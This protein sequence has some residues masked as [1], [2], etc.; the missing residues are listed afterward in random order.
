MAKPPIAP[1]KSAPVKPA[2]VSAKPARVEVAKPA[3]AAP[4]KR[5]KLVRDSFTIPKGE[6]AMLATLKER[7]I[8]L[9][10][11]A[12]KSELIRAGVQALAAM[13]DSGLLAALTRVP[14]I[15]TGRPAGVTKPAPK[16][17]KGKAADADKS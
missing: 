3:P 13:D 2:S 1:S 15:K 9:A 17:T 12:K 7:A 10:R 5:E 14:A 6:Y 4:R 8:G 16:T 11:P